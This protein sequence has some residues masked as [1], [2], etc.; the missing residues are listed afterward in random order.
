MLPDPPSHS[1][2]TSEQPVP[3]VTD[4]GAMDIPTVSKVNGDAKIVHEFDITDRDL[5]QVYTSPSPYNAAFEEIISRST[6]TTPSLLNDSCGG[7]TARV[8]RVLG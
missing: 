6:L 7:I 8:Y 1:T 5:Q 2:A 3:L 4:G